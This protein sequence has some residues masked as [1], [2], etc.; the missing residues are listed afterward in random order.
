LSPEAEEDL[1]DILRSVAEATSQ[2]VA[3]SYLDRIEA[4]LAGFDI[5]S[6]RGTLRDVVRPGL[7]ITGFEHRLTIAFT[8]TATDVIVLRVFARSRDWQSEFETDES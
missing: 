4:F 5:V 8:L 1:A 7:R 2:H 6:E 3:L